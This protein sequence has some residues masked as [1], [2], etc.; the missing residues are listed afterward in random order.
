MAKFKQYCRYCAHLC[1]GN[2]IWCSA[3]EKELAESTAKSTNHCRL[4]AFCV[5]DAF[6]ETGRYTP[7]QI[8]RKPR[9]KAVLENQMTMEE[10]HG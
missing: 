1:T 9:E 5:I 8:E 2:G 4:F 7:R 6:T 3:K 10:E